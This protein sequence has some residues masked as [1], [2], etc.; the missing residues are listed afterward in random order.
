[1]LRLLERIA[2]LAPA[3]SS[4]A[5]ELRASIVDNVRNICSSRLGAAPACPRY[6]LP[7]SVVYSP[8]EHEHT[9]A[10][11]LRDAV[12][13]SEPRVTNV[14]VSPVAVEPG[15]MER[16]FEITATLAGAPRAGPVHLR[17]RFVVGD[18]TVEGR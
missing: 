5:A 13:A 10:K 7:D 15:V 14:E 1:M 18:V 9:L 16:Q 6:G 8:Y 2:R 11:V 4:P 12:L 17:T 3:R